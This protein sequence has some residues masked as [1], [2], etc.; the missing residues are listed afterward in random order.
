M[1]Q[2][3]ELTIQL[4]QVNYEGHTFNCLP[5]LGQQEVLQRSQRLHLLAS[6]KATAR[7]PMGLY[8]LR[9]Q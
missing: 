7:R 8:S 2:I 3:Q 9:F 1:T 4:G 6:S 5:I